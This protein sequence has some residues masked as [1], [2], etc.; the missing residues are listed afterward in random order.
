MA[1]NNIVLMRGLKDGPRVTSHAYSDM[2]KHKLDFYIQ[3]NPDAPARIPKIFLYNTIFTRWSYSSYPTYFYSPM[4][5]AE[6]VQ[7][8]FFLPE[9]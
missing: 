8:N 4:T 5:V 2:G 3:L 9:M 1:K 6:K 7:I